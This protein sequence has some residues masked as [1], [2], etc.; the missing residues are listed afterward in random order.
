L[1]DKIRVIDNSDSIYSSFG[2]LNSPGT[3]QILDTTIDETTNKTELVVD[4]LLSNIYGSS[5]DTG[6]I[7]TKLKIV[8]N[9]E[10]VSWNSG[11]WNNGIFSAGR[12][13]GG[14]WYNGVFSGIWG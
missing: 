5:L 14:I 9:F 6:T 2:S 11:V 13:L 1:N 12:F 8:S 10:N 4:K 7:N 3:Y